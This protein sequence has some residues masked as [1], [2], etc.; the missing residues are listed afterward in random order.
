MKNFSAVD[1]N[2]L[3]K[4]FGNLHQAL[5]VLYVANG[6][7]KLARLSIYN[8]N[9]LNLAKNF[10]ENHRLK[11]VESSV[12]YIT[13]R[14]SNRTYFTSY[15]KPVALNNKK[16]GFIYLY[17]SKSNDLSQLGRICEE[18]DYS[19]QFGR[20]LDYPECCIDFYNKN[21]QRYLKEKRDLMHSV[22]DETEGLFPYPFWNNFVTRYFDA[23][24]LSH[25]PCSFNCRESMEMA[26]ER[27]ELIKSISS[28][29]SD[30]L[31]GQL[32]SVIIF[33]SSL[34]IYKL[35]DYLFKNNE[36]HF[37]KKG[38]CC[39]NKSYIRDILEKTTKIQVIT[40]KRIIFMQEDRILKD[41][42]GKD[43]GIFI[44]Q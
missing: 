3:T 23:S 12:K 17:I 31:I 21:I 14:D 18:H 44:F 39:I 20:I 24:L 9:R 28:S 27:L 13:K 11:I 37:N 1:L 10:I 42:N 36:V 32:K 41:L 4:L 8:K 5:E 33:T 43:I 2:L 26:K 6:L 16:G 34:G 29:L 19:I 7:K 15:S 25:Y 40:K 35:T 38:I 22:L 30:Y